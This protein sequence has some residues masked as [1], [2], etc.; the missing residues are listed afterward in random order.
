MKTRN[1]KIEAVR[2]VLKALDKSITKDGIFL[3]RVQ[4]KRNERGF[5]T[6]VLLTYEEQTDEEH[7]TAMEGKE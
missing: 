7:E 2:G 5:L 1:E 3:T 6:D 4:F